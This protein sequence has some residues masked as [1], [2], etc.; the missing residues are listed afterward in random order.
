MNPNDPFAKYAV[1][2][3]ATDRADPF[4]QY[5]ASSPQEPTGTSELESAGLG[6]L[7]GVSF[8]FADEIEAAVRSL[9][10]G[11]TYED[12]V[13][14]VRTRYKQAE[15]ANP[16]SYLAGEIGGG[17]AGALI[18]GIGAIGTAAKGA[19]LGQLAIAGAKAGALA[20]FGSGEGLGESLTSAATGAAI[21]A[22][23][24]PVIH[25]A[26]KLLGKRAKD[27]ATT[28][29]DEPI[30]QK[31]LEET[32]TPEVAA[33]QEGIADKLYKGEDISIPEDSLV[34]FAKSIKV[35]SEEGLSPKTGREAMEVI[36]DARIKLG[37]DDFKRRYH[38]WAKVKASKTALE[39]Q[40]GPN[41]SAV[42]DVARASRVLWDGM[43][44]FKEIDTRRGSS[45]LEAAL[46][47]NRAIANATSDRVNW[48][49][50]AEKLIETSSDEIDEATNK[51]TAAGVKL[52]GKAGERQKE[53]LN[54]FEDIRQHLI[55]LGVPVA[56][57]EMYIPA[58]T[59]SAPEAIYRVGR[60]VEEYGGLEAVAK[61]MP[62][63]LKQ[64]I[65]YYTG[66]P[67]EGIEGAKVLESILTPGSA[68]NTREKLTSS[69][70]EY[71]EGAIP[72][73]LR[74]YNTA[75]LINRYLSENL[76]YAHLREPLADLKLNKQ[77]LQA[78]DKTD[79]DAAF[80]DKAVRGF[81]G[82]R[83]GI[84][85]GIHN[86][87]VRTQVA[88]LKAADES[89]SKLG[90]KFY[91]TIAD[92]PEVLSNLMSNIYRNVL[93]S[94][95]AAV[96]NF[97]GL[98]FQT[99]PELGWAFGTKELMGATSRALKRIATDRKSYIDEMTA[100]GFI[101]PE[102]SDIG[103]LIA[104][105]PPGVATKTFNKLGDFALFAFK[106]VERLN[107]AVLYEVGKDL[108]SKWGTNEADKF[109]R[110]IPAS[111]RKKL[112]TSP[113]EVRERLLTLYIQDRGAASYNKLAR[114]EASRFVGPMFSMFTKYPGVMAGR[115]GSA[116]ATEGGAEGAKEITTKYVAPWVAL[117]MM[118]YALKESGSLDPDTEHY[119][120]GK[121]G[122]AGAAP[123]PAAAN[124]LGLAS[125][126]AP[127]T[128]LVGGV[129]KA[130]KSA[131]E[132]NL[133]GAVNNLNSLSSILLPGGL[134]GY[135]KFLQDTLRWQGV[136]SED[137]T[138]L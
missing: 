93:S 1:E 58:K 4:A 40:L 72:E 42:K 51:A 55:S 101:G 115:I 57:R 6:A 138:L 49:K 108:S 85:A 28:V 47:T 136:L 22:G 69:L 118:S 15:E 9:A 8:N 60:K 59:V 71:T 27:L 129:L 32:Y 78:K 10:P 75:K 45:T 79:A 105:N 11:E 102:M 68:L 131:A 70:F 36:D 35:V 63:E 17:L 98:Y 122:L 24:V 34:D 86:V 133:E 21:G 104:K 130:G 126:R 91:N 82:E 5:V 66:R 116:I 19:K 103:H 134:A 2:P 41:S 94:P 53:I 12:A 18:P 44:V 128:Q 64:T 124:V 121:E 23:L 13:A 65:T 114:S 89:T 123:L 90:K 52:D 117:N 67:A 50:K 62:E 119:F 76:N 61:N 113:P 73:Y 54:Y 3:E 80:L 39:M 46:Q 81:L 14:K 7:Q 125:P 31:V 95:K 29:S 77:L 25:G 99:I 26:G 87:M 74:E 111:L 88:A 132:G 84:D 30:I 96:Q 48:T 56:K 33:L 100:K 127:T 20:G 16:K 83:F 107:R 112:D 37:A 106:G 38:D 43:D 109:A 97:S 120:F 110:T 92:S 135:Y 137:E